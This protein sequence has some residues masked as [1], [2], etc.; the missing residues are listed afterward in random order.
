MGSRIGG[1]KGLVR[2]C[3]RPMCLHVVDAVS[4][5][6]D[7]I[8]LAVGRGRG[9][10]YS[11]LLDP[12]IRVVEDTVTGKGP[13]EGLV[14]A[15]RLAKEQQVIV[16]PCDVPLARTEVL[17]LLASRAAGADGAVPIVRGF[18]EPLVAVYGRDVGLISFEDELVTGTGKVSD[19]LE[20][21]HVVRVPESDLRMSDPELLTFWNVN[22]HEDL[23]RA[24]GMLSRSYATSWKAP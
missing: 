17:E 7:D 21:M 20:N 10:Q 23:S 15:F 18:V 3:S 24:E 4:R 22:S 11:S 19:A 12:R 2:V 13:L 8:M 9:T 5:V 1:D 6:T 16:L 14:N